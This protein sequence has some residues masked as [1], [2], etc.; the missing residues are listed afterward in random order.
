[1]LNIDRCTNRKTSEVEMLR[2]A[3]VLLVSLM[4][5][6]PIGVSADD[7]NTCASDDAPPRRTF[8]LTSPGIQVITGEL[9]VHLSKSSR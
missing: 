2:V 7:E 1:M 3:L 6:V 8:D 5:L 4:A 9:V